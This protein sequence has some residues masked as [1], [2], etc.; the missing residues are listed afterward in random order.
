MK[1]LAGLVLVV[2]IAAGLL[3]ISRLRTSPGHISGFVE[4]DEV[5]VGSRVGGRVAEVLV[6]EGES[7]SPEQVLVRLAPYD[8]KERLAEAEAQLAARTAVFE[9]LESGL[10][11]EEIAQAQAKVDGLTATVAKLVS[12]PRAEEIAAATSR[13]EL[14]KAQLDR[15]AQSNE[16]LQSLYKRDATSVSREDLDRGVEE[17]K[18]AE[19][20][21]RVRQEELGLLKHGTRQEEITEARAQLE[22]AT[23]AL[24]MA[25]N[26]YR[27][28][29]I[30]EARAA[31]DAAKASVAAVKVQI[32][33]LE[34][35]SGVHGRVEA[36][37]LRPGD[38][39]APGG[40]VL[41]ILDTERLWV[42]AYLPENRLDI[43]VGDELP[44]TVDSYPSQT[45]VG[46]VTYLSTQA[47]FTP[48]NIQTADERIKQVF[49]IKVELTDPSHHL[50]PGMSADLH[51][52]SPNIR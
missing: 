21:H 35:K 31:M 27:A 34:I 5:R 17:L 16:R 40:P 32:G 48:R 25:K 3:T 22:Q 4:A 36:L 13:L 44:I 18:V 1:Q 11:P 46:R 42:R 19:A 7:V 52:P 50:H 26:G 37:E 6:A 2:V 10:R 9:R 43:K 29:E 14:A 8:L 20:N 45:F 49:R 39:V 12:G 47:E 41:S 51:L 38:L 28:E 33:E 24:Q 15:A 23:Q 30:A